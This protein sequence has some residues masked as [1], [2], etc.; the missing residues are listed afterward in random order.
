MK[1][2]IESEWH[3]PGYAFIHCERE[4]RQWGSM[5]T[6][7]CWLIVDKQGNQRF[8]PPSL[9]EEAC[10]Y[11]Q[12]RIGAHEAQGFQGTK[13]VVVI[14]TSISIR[15]IPNTPKLHQSNSLC[16]LNFTSAFQK[17][18]VLIRRTLPNMIASYQRR[19][20]AVPNLQLTFFF[21]ILLVVPV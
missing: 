21:A 5:K 16:W 2:N 8:C 19:W 15:S 14:S 6:R 11:S 18:M 13:R 7:C 4:Q 20:I 17:K 10:S 12:M 3:F 1:L 9:I